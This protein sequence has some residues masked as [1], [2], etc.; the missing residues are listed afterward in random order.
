MRDEGSK[1]GNAGSEGSAPLARI[2]RHHKE[3][4]KK[5]SLQ[6]L[7]EDPRFDFTRWSPGTKIDASGG[8]LLEIDAPPLGP[9]DAGHPL[10][11]LDSTWRYLPDMRASVHGR[12]LS[13]SLP[14]SVRTAYPRVAVLSEN[15]EPGLASIE[16]L[17]AA[18]RILG[19]R[20][21]DLLRNYHWRADFLA[22]VA[23]L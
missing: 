20:D 14:R 22:I 11:L 18:L 9:E 7:V 2:W 13:R 8:I 5:C 17:Y 3:R 4:L 19:Q 16:A 12:Y 10:I 1:P 21:D 6:P 23:A 15:P